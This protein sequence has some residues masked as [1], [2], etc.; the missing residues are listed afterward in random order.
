L[1]VLKKLHSLVTI[2]QTFQKENK[3]IQ[4][5]NIDVLKFRFKG[6]IMTFEKTAP[7]LNLA[8]QQMLRFKEIPDSCDECLGSLALTNATEIWRKV[9]ADYVVT[10][11]SHL[12]HPSSFVTYSANVF[13]LLSKEIV[14]QPESSNSEELLRR[15]LTQS[16]A[17]SV[18][19]VLKEFFFFSS[20]V[21]WEISL[22]GNL[23]KLN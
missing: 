16:S 1:Y 4:N 13:K 6:G 15:I 8:M 22:R 17:V 5:N 19:Y 21:S 12:N 10:S 9:K 7:I 23:F 3:R 14:L 2:I 11:P 18:P 20:I